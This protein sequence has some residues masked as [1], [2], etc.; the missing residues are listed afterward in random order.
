MRNKLYAFNLSETKQ[1]WAVNV[2]LSFSFSLNG[3]LFLD[4]RLRDTPDHQ[5]FT[6]V[7]AA[8][9]LKPSYNKRTFKSKGYN[10]QTS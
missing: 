6:E 2:I 8:G 5:K 9:N 10:N 7:P 1:S 4:L 3:V